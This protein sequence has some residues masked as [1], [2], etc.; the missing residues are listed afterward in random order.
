VEPV[1]E[2]GPYLFVVV[3]L[4]FFLGGEEGFEAMRYL[5]YLLRWWSH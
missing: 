1:Y 2:E 3:I 4:G 5:A